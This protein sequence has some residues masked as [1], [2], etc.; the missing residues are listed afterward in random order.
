MVDTLTT[1]YIKGLNQLKTE[2]Q[3]YSSETNIWVIKDGITN[4]SGILAKHLIG[5]LNHYIGA[6]IGNSEYIRNREREFE[7]QPVPRE[8]LLKQIDVLIETLQK[9]LSELNVMLLPQEYPLQVFGHPMTYQFFL[10]HLL[11]HLNYHLG[12]VNYHR[13]IIDSTE[14][15]SRPHT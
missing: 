3:A 13:R 2:L 1:L 7:N 12:Q 9:V 15:R 4:S 8:A 5:N 14:F 11:G 6:V 10:I